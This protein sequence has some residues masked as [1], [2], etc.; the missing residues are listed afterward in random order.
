MKGLPW[1]DLGI[2]NIYAHNNPLERNNM[3]ELMKAYITREYK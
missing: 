2:I 3:W 1:G